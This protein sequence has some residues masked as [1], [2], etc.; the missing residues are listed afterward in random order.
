MDRDRGWRDAHP[1]PH[2]P[3]NPYLVAIATNNI[4]RGNLS[5]LNAVS[6][7]F[8]IIA[9]VMWF[10]QYWENL[11]L[12]YAGQSVIYRMRTELFEHL[13]RL[14]LSF[15][16]RNKVG[17]L[18]S[19]VQN[20]VQQLQELVTQGILSLITSLLTLVGIVIIML[21]MN[22]LLGLIMLTMVPVMALA[23]WVWQKYARQ[24]F[25]RGAAGRL[26][27][28]MRSSRKTSPG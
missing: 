6:L 4:V 26:P 17:K 12:S 25:I 18:M 20:D 19:R 8:V 21:T 11:Y 27:P 15:F 2:H 3:G 10:R 24:A 13:H 1:H 22:W 7:V 28:S 9:V 5:G 16:D 23:V 14:S